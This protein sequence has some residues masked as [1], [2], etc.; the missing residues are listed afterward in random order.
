MVMSMIHRMIMHRIN[1][2]EAKVHLSKYLRRVRK[3]E[4]ILLCCR[5]VP[6]AE[7]RPIRERPTARRHIGLLRGSLTIPDEFFEPLPDDLIDAFEG[8]GGTSGA[9]GND[10]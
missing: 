6:V 8:G 1:I 4:T 5:N 3:G 2:A 7:I 10:P 9:A